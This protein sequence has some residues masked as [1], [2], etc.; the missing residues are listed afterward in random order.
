MG[1]DKSLL[2]SVRHGARFVVGHGVKF[3]VEHG[4]R[5]AMGYRMDEICV[6]SQY[7]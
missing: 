1:H 2:P 7:Q 6:C 3:S 4:A 5:F